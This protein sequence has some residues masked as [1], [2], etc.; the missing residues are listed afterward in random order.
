MGKI[1][2]VVQRNGFAA[3]VTIVG[4]S[5]LGLAAVLGVAQAIYTALEPEN[6]SLTGAASLCA[7]SATSG[8]KYVSFGSACPGSPSTTPPPSTPPTT[9]PVASASPCL[10]RSSIK[11]TSGSFMSQYSTAPTNGSTVD[12]RNGSWTMSDGW[13][14][15][16]GGGTDVCWHGGSLK[17]TVNDQKIGRAHV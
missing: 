10:Q 11:T 1:R 17:L 3:V 14:A 15:T 4:T 7:D 2:H 13:L 16:P 5:I 8:G 6:S 9:P 12:A